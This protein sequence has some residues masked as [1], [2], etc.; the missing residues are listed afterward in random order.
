MGR[1]TRTP[2]TK[3]PTRTFGSPSPTTTSTMPS[4]LCHPVC[5][6]LPSCLLP[7]EET[8]KNGIA[9]ST[10]LW[11]GSSH[12]SQS[13]ASQDITELVQHRSATF[14]LLFLYIFCKSC[15]GLQ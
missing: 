12:L 14:Y 8:L 15:K 3:R 11:D 13:K 9:T 2:R 4:C 5:P 1:T 7:T 10:P 6:S